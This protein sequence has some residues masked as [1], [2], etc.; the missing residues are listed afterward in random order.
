M[1]KF[2][3]NRDFYRHIAIICL[4]IVLQ[5]VVTTFVSL[6]DNIMVGQ[7]GTASISGVAV[8]GQLFFIYNV[9]IFGT[10]SGPGI[11]CAQFWG[12]R[13]ERSF[14]AAFRYKLILALA[15]CAVLF[16][17]LAIWGQDLVGLY[18]HGDPADKAEIMGYAMPYLRIMLWGMLPYAVM[19]AYSSTLRE[20]GQTL[21]PM[22]SSWAAVGL[23]LFLN[24]VLIFGKLGAPA[25]GARGAAVATVISRVC[26]MAVNVGWSHAHGKEVRFSHKILE[27][28]PMP[29]R[30]LRELTSKSIPLLLNETLW[31]VGTAT[32]MQIYSTRG[33]E[34]VAALQIGLVVLDLMNAVAFSVGT[35]IGIV[36]GQE[37]GAGDVERAVDTDRKLLAL[38]FAVAAAIGLSALGVAGWFPRLYKTTPEIRSL[39]SKLIRVMAVALPFDCFAHGCYFTMR[40]GGNTA[41]TF[42]FDSVFSWVVNVPVAYMLAHFTGLGIMWVYTL[43]V[44]TVLIKCFVGAVFVHRRLWVN[45]FQGLRRS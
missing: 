35:T 32:L 20:T 43:S 12:A 10:V 26:E 41:V 4:P 8:V 27:G 17:V 7:T 21:V 42:L 34:V 30:L 16:S 38:G 2:I 3:G 25:M 15:V 36:V 13:D 45:T 19:M 31:C 39:A 40:S 33:L 29:S 6:L 14:R 9:V 18:L 44:S 1:R 24:W 11:F 22:I 23:N 28:F 5:N 37:L